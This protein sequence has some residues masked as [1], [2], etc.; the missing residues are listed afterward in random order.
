LGSSGLFFKYP[1][2]LP[3]KARRKPRLQAHAHRDLVIAIGGGGWQGADGATRHNLR[4]CPLQFVVNW[5]PLSV[6]FGSIRDIVRHR[7][8]WNGF[9][10]RAFRSRHN[11]PTRRII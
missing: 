9:R 7:L 5:A 2:F 10:D 8:K 3:T 11:Q 6:T 4:H 1:I